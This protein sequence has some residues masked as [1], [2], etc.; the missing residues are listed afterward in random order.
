MSRIED[1]GFR[2]CKKRRCRIHSHYRCTPRYRMTS[3]PLCAAEQSQVRR[4]VSCRG[5]WELRILA[6]ARQAYGPITYRF[7]HQCASSAD[8]RALPS[9]T[10]T[11]S[12]VYERWR[13][14]RASFPLATFLSD[15]QRKV[16]SC[17][18]APDAS[19]N[20]NTIASSRAMAAR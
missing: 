1:R 4:G 5:L 11:P 6:V 12:R 20:R 18:A 3:G 13:L 17:R 7:R 14:T 19:L 9:S 16:A 15:E 10:G 2:D 8:R